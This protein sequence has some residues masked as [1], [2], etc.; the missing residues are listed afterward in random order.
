[1]KSFIH[2][3]FKKVRLVDKPDEILQNHYNKRRILRLR[4][5]NDSLQELQDV[6]QELGDRYAESMYKK[7]MGELKDVGDCEIGG[8]N[9][10]KLWKLKNKLSPRYN[11]PPAAMRNKEGKLLTSPDEILKETEDHY[12]NVFNEKPI[13]DEHKEFKNQREELC[14]KRLDACSKVK[15]PDWTI[16]DVKYVLNNLK[17]GKSKD[18]YDLPNEIFKDDTAGKDLVC[19]NNKINESY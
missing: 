15:S 17:A 5:D 10:G 11:D 2:K 6:E 18:A 19:S 13:D 7:I 9:S 8:F 4:T 16:N 14:K 12:K 1:M 3:N